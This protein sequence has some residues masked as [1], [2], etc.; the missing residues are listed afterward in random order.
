MQIQTIGK[1]LQQLTAEGLLYAPHGLRER[2]IAPTRAKSRQAGDFLT[3]PAW[4]ESASGN[5]LSQSGAPPDSVH[6][7]IPQTASLLHWITKQ[8]DGAELVAR[9]PTPGI[10]RLPGS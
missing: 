4:T 5:N 7:L 2:R 9:Y 10:I 3:D 1:A 6:V 8:W